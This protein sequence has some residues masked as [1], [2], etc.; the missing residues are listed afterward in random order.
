MQNV[1]IEKPYEFIPPYRGTFWAKAIQHLR[2]VD[3]Y[4]RHWHGVERYECRGV[5][6]LKASLAAG[7]GILLTP[8]HCR[9]CD[10]IAMG[11]LARDAETLC[12]GMASWHLFHDHWAVSTALVL[13]GAFSVYR[14][15]IDRKAISEAIQILETAERP[16]II[17]PEGAVTRTNDRLHALL[18]GVA[19][20]ARSAAKKRAR[21][22]NPGKVVI[23]P[24]AVKYFFQGDLLA[25]VDPVLARIEE[26]LSWRPQREV[27]LFNRI[28]KLGYALLALKEIE[29]F[30]QPQSG[31][32]GDRIPALID[33]L[34]GPLE[35]EWFGARQGGGVVPRVKNLR[36]KITP[37]MTQGTLAPEERARRWAQLADIYLAQ[38]VSCY[39][40]D[41]LTERL[42]IDRLLETVERYEE[43]LTDKVTVHGRLKVVMEV[44]DPIEVSTERE[45]GAAV[46]PLMAELERRLQ[47]MLDALGKESKLYEEAMRRA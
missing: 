16:L 37:E 13:I 1:V 32:L 12:Y 5:E 23:H 20:I 27:P 43:D 40:I 24:V 10:P 21:A 2:L 19:F 17:F 4:L 36:M 28:A 42:S 8:N 29:F 35:E 26:R 46:D 3:Y 6:K 22:E 30:G 45:R 15:G 33:R 47:G 44:G 38:Q 11:L 31:R 41:Y 9:P 25:T 7:H 39:P 34:L 18:D 14:E